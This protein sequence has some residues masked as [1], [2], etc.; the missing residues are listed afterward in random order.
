MLS[1]K[2]T[3]EIAVGGRTSGLCEEG[4]TI[5][6]EA[7]HFLIRQRLTVEITKMEKPVFFEDRMVKGAF[8]SMRHEHHFEQADSHTIMRDVF[9]YEVPYGIAGWIFDKVILRR[10]MTRFLRTRNE[11]IK[12]MAEGSGVSG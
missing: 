9:M 1:T 4:D 12:R 8:K 6:W 2:D 7:T 3:K 11:M 10:Y 5:T